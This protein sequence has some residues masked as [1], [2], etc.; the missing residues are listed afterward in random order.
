[1]KIEAK[2]LAKLLV[3]TVV[4][5]A[6]TA[7]LFGGT[8]PADE[9]GKVT[10]TR[11][12]STA[13]D[14]EVIVPPPPG[15]ENAVQRSAQAA[16]TAANGKYVVKPGDSLWDIAQR[17]LG[18]GKRFFELVEM[19]RAKYPSLTNNPSLIHSGWE[20]DLPDGATDPK[21]DSDS[22]SASAPEEG[23]VRVDSSLNIRTSPWGSIIGS[24]HDNDKVSIIGKSGDWYKISYNGQTAYVHSNYV[25]T[26]TKPAG[27]TPVQNPGGKDTPPPSLRH[28]VAAGGS[29]RPPASPCPGM[30]PRSS[31]P[32]IFTG[33]STMGLTFPSPLEPASMLWATAWLSVSVTS[34]AAEPSSK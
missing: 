31:A 12:V 29:A 28:P 15:E 10:P 16:A 25:S 5:L 17:F 9:D 33:A 22:D 18:D 14:P 13:D 3:L 2:P 30:H 8:G 7:T 27:T 26:A 34:P 4:V 32:A 6:W 23:T 19:N 24:L 11:E 21:A 20:L 1:M